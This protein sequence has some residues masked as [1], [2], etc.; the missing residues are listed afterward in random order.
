[1]L[2]GLYGENGGS[3]DPQNDYF[4]LNI[5]AGTW[6]AALTARQVVW[7]RGEDTLFYLR[8]FATTPLAEGSTRA[9]WTSQ[10]AVFDLAT[11]KDTELTTGLVLNDSMASCGPAIK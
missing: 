10:L 11:R 9:V 7:L 8:P 2:A 3:G 1:M 5:A 6:T 4:R